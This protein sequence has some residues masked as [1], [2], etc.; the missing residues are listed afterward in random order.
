[1][2]PA[3][4]RTVEASG[5]RDPRRDVAGAAGVPV[6]RLVARGAAALPLRLRVPRRERGDER[7]DD[8]PHPAR[9]RLRDA[10][11]A[12]AAELPQVRAAAGGTGRLALELAR[13]CEAPQ[14]ADAAARL[15]LLAVRRAPLR[16]R[17]PRTLRLRRRRL[18]GRLRPC[19]GAAAAGAPRAARAGS[20]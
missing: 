17:A 19:A 14:P 4:R 15:E 3:P 1:M 11:A 18:G 7:A 13:A 16:H 10:R 6:R 12:P 5:A 2:C 8:E 9:R 20:R